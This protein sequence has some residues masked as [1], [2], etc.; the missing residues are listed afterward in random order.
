MTSSH[1]VSDAFSLT[2]CT[3]VHKG[4]LRKEQR[5]KENGIRN[6]ILRAKRLS[7][8]FPDDSDEISE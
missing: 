2:V 4:L 1:F 5:K 6:H 8:S 3:Q 7:R